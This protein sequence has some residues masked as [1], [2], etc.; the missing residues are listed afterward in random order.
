M[1]LSVKLMSKHESFHSKITNHPNIRIYGSPSLWNKGPDDIQ[2]R[3]LEKGGVADCLRA[4]RLPPSPFMP[5]T[6]KHVVRIL[7]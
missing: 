5:G 7:G 1:V 2:A 4:L 6:I 3:I